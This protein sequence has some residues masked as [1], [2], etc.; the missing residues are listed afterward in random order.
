MHRPIS[1]VPLRQ[2]IS[3]IFIFDNLRGE[4]YYIAFIHISLVI[5]VVFLVIHLLVICVSFVNCLCP[6]PRF[7]LW[8]LSLFLTDLHELIVYEIANPLSYSHMDRKKK[9]Y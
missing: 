4:R 7:S 3:F 9:F 8:H 1:T 6:L 5:S 2:W